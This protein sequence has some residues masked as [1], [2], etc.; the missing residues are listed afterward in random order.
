MEINLYNEDCMEGMKRYPD[1]YF[2]LAIVDPPY[3]I[4]ESNSNFESRNRPIKQKN[5]SYLNA[6]NRNYVRKKWDSSIPNDDYFSELKRVSLNQIIWG[7]NHF[8]L[9]GSSGRI[10]WDKCN[11]DNDFSDCEI[12]WGSM[13]DSVRLFR[14]MWAGMFQGF[15]IKE[16]HIQQGNKALN[17]LR[18]HPTQKPVKLYEWLLKNYAKQ[19][20]KILD[21]HLGSGS[22]AIACYNLDYSLT[23][24]EID[25]DYYEGAIQ[26]LET[27]KKQ[28]RLFDGN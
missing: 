14:Y 26:R 19:G 10:V 22:I 12:A 21:T 3:G 13:F 1:K 23:G 20:D 28:Q 7:C 24:F 6:P 8:N 15:S 17:E 25:R 4:G 2:E 9:Q 18:I 27:H 11:G 5:G 16:G